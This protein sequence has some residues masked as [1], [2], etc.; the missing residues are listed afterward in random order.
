MNE[1]QWEE[2][3]RAITHEVLAGVQNVALYTGGPGHWGVGIDLISD[4][5]Q[6]L[7]RKIVSTRGEVVKPMLAARLGLS[8]KME[9]LARRLGAL[10]VRPED[11][12]APW[13]KEVH[14]I[15]REV[16]EAAGEDAEVRLDEAGHWRVG[17]EVFDEERFELRFRVLATTRGD[18]PLPLLAEKLGLSA[19]AAE[20]ARRLGALG[21]RPEDTP[22]PEE[23]AAM[24]PE[25]VEALRLGLDIGVHSLPRLLD[26]CSHSSWTELGDERALRKVLKEF[27]QDVRKRLEEEKAWPEVLEA[28]RLEAAFKDLLDSGIVAQ[29]GGGNTLSS[30]W[31]AVREEA[32][33]L[34]E[35]GLELWGAAF[36]HEQDIE[37]A[38]AGGSL[39]IA[40]GELDEEPSDKDVQTGQAVVEA[41]RKHG[42]EPDWNGSADT[43]IQVLPRFTW[44]RRRS[45]VDTLEHLSI[46]TFPADLVE[47]LPQLRTIWMR[48]AELYL[49]DLAGMWSD[50]VEQ[51]TLEYDS[52]GDALEALADVTALV[53]KRFPRLQTLIVKDRNSFE[54]TVTLSG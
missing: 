24:I 8:A 2:Q 11:T 13:E 25:A 31:S 41:L 15:A 3:V 6:V 28:D 47:L 49:Y 35:R 27:S 45:R 43:R 40:F 29:M 26:D 50:S 10:G 4:L 44:R 14:A 5:G 54:E 53:K 42:F 9:E 34:R 33:E 19:Q 48:A 30:G 21:V 38:L 32:D 1:E 18:V 20:L 36:F 52:E 37:S 12:L 16:L 17:L 46:G 39:H 23:E 22:L 7:E 51:L